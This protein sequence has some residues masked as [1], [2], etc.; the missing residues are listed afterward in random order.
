MLSLRVG[1][2]A[3]GYEDADDCDTL[4][5]DRM[6]KLFAERAPEAAPLA[7]QPTM[8]RLENSLTKKE[9]WDI[10]EVFVNHFISSYRKA[11]KTI[12]IDC[13][14]TNANTYGGQQLT[15]FNNYYGEYC[16][17][18]LL[19]FEGLSGKL[20]LPMLRLGRGN[21]SINIAGLII[22]LVSRLREVW[23]K[24][25]IVVRGDSHF[26]SH[27]FMDW[28]VSQRG[29]R[30]VTGLTGNSVLNRK[31]ERWVAYDKEV[32]RSTRQPSKRYHEFMYK[33]G[34]WK[35]AQRVIV[36]IEVGELG[37]NVRFIVTNFNG[38]RKDVY[39]TGYC[40]RGA[41][42][43]M[44]K[45]LKTFLHADRMSCNSFAANQFRLYMHAAAY[46]LLLSMEH[47]LLADTDFEKCSMLTLV[48]KLM[49]TAVRVEV[50]KSG[51]R[52]HFQSGHLFREQLEWALRTAG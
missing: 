27:E 26:C 12:I 10:G 46:V 43:L 23:K 9:L 18:P 35:N 24:T 38:P 13:D 52:L 47:I 5:D 8:S 51:I 37:E 50:K 36:K 28:A 1:Q 25:E 14:D 32:Y 41:M 7:S 30:F 6:L 4:R 48:T 33:A 16:Y 42:E 39:E 31:V 29:V 2:I 21:K 40:G 22:R 19:I 17:M 3:C 49:L 45:E 44:I 15:L 20:I 34:S 11:P